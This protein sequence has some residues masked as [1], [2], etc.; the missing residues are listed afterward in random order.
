MCACRYAHM[1]MYVMCVSVHAR[2]RGAVVCRGISR[3]S[4]AN[5]VSQWCEETDHCTGGL[6]SPAVV[7]MTEC[8][9]SQIEK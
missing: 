9:S 5:L 1:H 2:G 6:K 3:L 4:K 7:S 8:A